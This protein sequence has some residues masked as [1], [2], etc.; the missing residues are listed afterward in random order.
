MRKTLDRFNNFV[1]EL[2]A[3]QGMSLERAKE[4]ARILSRMKEREA[5]LTESN[6]P[7][8]E[9]EKEKRK[10]LEYAKDPKSDCYFLRDDG[11]LSRYDDSRYAEFASN[12]CGM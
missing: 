5:E 8:V 2:I 1:C 12:H 6:D 7:E 10:R 4:A 9:R 3:E 11:T